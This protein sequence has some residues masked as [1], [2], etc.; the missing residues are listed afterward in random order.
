MQVRVQVHAYVC[1][2]VLK[3][4]ESSDDSSHLMT[5]SYI[6]CRSPAK[7][8]ESSD[9]SNESSVYFYESSAHIFY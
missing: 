6:F 3:F 8:T 7:F 5:H 1:V 9:D 4:T 2:C